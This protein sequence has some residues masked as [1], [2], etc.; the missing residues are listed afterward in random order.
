MQSAESLGAVLGFDVRCH[1]CTDRVTAEWLWDMTWVELR[2]GK[3]I[4]LPLAL[5]SEW[6]PKF[7]EILFDFERLLVSRARLRVMIFEAPLPSGEQRFNRLIDAI[8]SY[9][10]TQIGDHYLLACWCYGSPP[11]HLEFKTYIVE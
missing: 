2:D 9:S 6:N 1:Q 3:L 10:G 8:R 5:E 7:E 4:D 11:G